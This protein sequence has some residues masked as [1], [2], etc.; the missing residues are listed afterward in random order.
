LVATP[1]SSQDRFAKDWSPTCGARYLATSALYGLIITAPGSRCVVE[2]EAG[3][4]ILG[5]RW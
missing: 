3:L 2:L 1:V 4:M 5:S